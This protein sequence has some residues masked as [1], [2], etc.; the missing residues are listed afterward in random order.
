MSPS[1]Q[2]GEDSKSTATAYEARNIG[3]NGHNRYL[4]SVLFGSMHQKDS[5]VLY[6]Y[7]GK[8]FLNSS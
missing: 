1:G 4:D 6:V 8:L 2:T 7:L 3:S 5:G